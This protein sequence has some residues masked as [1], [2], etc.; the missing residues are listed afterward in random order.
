MR[1]GAMKSDEFIIPEQVLIETVNGFCTADCIMCSK[2]RWTRTP[3]HMNDETYIGILN[4]L[5]PYTRQIKML[6]LFGCGEPLLDKK[7][8]ERVA[9]AK[10]KGFQGIGIAT[11]C[12]ELDAKKARGLIRVGLN[13]I[14]C[15]LDGYYAE[16][17]EKIRRGT[18]F[19]EVAENIKNFIQI[20]DAV[21]GKHTKVVIR[22]I[23]QEINRE[24]WCLF[25]K[26]W[27]QRISPEYGDKVIKFDVHN[28]G[29]KVEDYHLKDPNRE[30]KLNNYVCP[31]LSKKLL[32]R[33][34]GEISFCDTDD[35]V[36]FKL[37]NACIEDPVA[38]YNRGKFVQYR[39]AMAEGKIAQLEYCK[40]C[41]LPRSL[42]LKREECE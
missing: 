20:R 1:D 40:A 2:R 18:V 4:N 23:R 37:G 32:L 25:K 28:W 5:K 29:G 9:L 22:F 33:S 36:F 30:I 41:S 21:N 10:E 26:Y 35:N 13:T 16:T 34:K 15:S 7:L 3:H 19:S 6:S 24:E 17:H 27:S 31:D 42:L 38:I 8:V 12:T 39:K 11:N 14:I